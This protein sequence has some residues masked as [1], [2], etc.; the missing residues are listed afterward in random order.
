MTI[1]IEDSRKAYEEG[2]R[3]ASWMNQFPK[4]KTLVLCC[5]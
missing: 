4:D 2:L 3:F 5:A 1:K